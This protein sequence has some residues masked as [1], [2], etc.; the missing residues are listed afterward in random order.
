MRP[1][2]HAQALLTILH[3][4]QLEASAAVGLRGERARVAMRD[5]RK[6]AQDERWRAIV[7]GA[8]KTR[9]KVSDADYRATVH[10]DARSDSATECRESASTG[11]E[12]GATHGE[13]E[14]VASQNEEASTPG[15]AASGVEDAR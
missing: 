2:A 8:T 15:F 9:I 1:D 3:E 11:D 14:N 10:D 12:S 4:A 7:R 13:R 5:A 6:A